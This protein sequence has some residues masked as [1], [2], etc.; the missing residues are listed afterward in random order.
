MG[1]VQKDGFRTMLISY[2]GMALGYLNKGVLFL[3]ILTSEQMGLINL[4]TTVGLLF[5]QLAS[6]GSMA[7]I[8]RFF[9]Y[10]R[11]S[12]K[13]NHGFLTL[14]LSIVGLGILLCT[15]AIFVFRE[16]IQAYYGE[17]SAL[18]LHYYLWV[19]PIG[20]SYVIY[21]VL[22]TYLRAMYKNIIAVFAFEVVLRLAVTISL[23]LYW[24]QAIDFHAFVVLNSLIYGVP[25]IILVL[26][27]IAIKEFHLSVSSIQI[28]RRFRKI[29]WNFSS[30]N[31]VNSLGIILVTSLD[32][33][34]IAQMLGLDATGVYTFVIFMTSALLVPYR[35]LVRISAPL[36]AD[37]W[38]QRQFE[39]MSALYTK[40]SS[41]ALVVGLGAF[42]VVW[43]NI[44]FLFQL[45]P[46][47]KY[48]DFLP[49]IW[50][51]FFL[52]LGRLI[53]MYAGLNG[54][55]F[56]TSKKY[57]FDIYF[58]IGLIG[59]V[60][61][62]NLVMI[63]KWGIAGAAISSAIALAVFNVGRLLFVYSVYKIHPFEKRQFA[64]IALGVATLFVGQFVSPFIVNSWLN[65][66]TQTT[67]FGILYCIPIYTFNLEPNTVDYV[68]KGL[69]F[70]KKKIAR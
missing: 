49:G 27:L 44:D 60:Y 29:I 28:S 23:F 70:I 47:D 19:I 65:A 42:L 5:A 67:L 18:F 57:R 48:A 64:V 66:L 43:M 15:L 36:V 25:V 56:T 59:V 30:Y 17:R 38:K 58:T 50:V 7:S 40:V 55:I 14:N 26:Y 69:L 32:V 62:G 12:E 21:M 16:Q 2:F 11:N 33:I 1:I 54:S 41:V 61:L 53:D 24:Y 45:I 10:F 13:R 4:L 37:H 31:Y 6:F 3:L 39:E 9:P 34:M 51:F 22:E 52:M 46:S 68:N 8:W 63:P 20:A 35:S